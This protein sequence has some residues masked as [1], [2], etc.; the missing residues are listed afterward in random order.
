MHPASEAASAETV[1][2]AAVTRT[3]ARPADEEEDAW[4]AAGGAAEDSVAAWDGTE[5]NGAAAGDDGSGD[6]GRE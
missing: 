5:G 2:A 4:D 1:T 3:S 6:D